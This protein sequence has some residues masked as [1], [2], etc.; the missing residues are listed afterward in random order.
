MK[1][2]NI[3][4]SPAQLLANKRY[5]QRLKEEMALPNKIVLSED[6]NEI[7]DYARSQGVSVGK[8]NKIRNRIWKKI[9]LQLGKDRAVNRMEKEK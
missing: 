8:I 3:E 7:A 9:R 1:S 6:Y 5:Q 4:L 2:E